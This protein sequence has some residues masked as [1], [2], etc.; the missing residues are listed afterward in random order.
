MRARGLCVGALTL[1][2]HVAAAA[3]P[4]EHGAHAEHPA[5]WSMLAFHALGLTILIGVLVYFA[6][7]PLKN[8]LRDRSDNLRRQLDQAKAAVQR[9]E[10]AN[11]EIAA[12]LARIADENETLVREAADIAELERVRAVERAEA[13]ADR[14]REEAKR[15]ADQEIE[16]ARAALQTEAAKLAVSLAGEMVKANL[17][18]EDDRR[19]LSD[20]VARIGGPS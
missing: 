9:A 1:V 5:D 13:A 6:G 3:E 16:R 14:V 17:T 8:F 12:R 15:A 7:E 11:A 10:A 19:L 20:F 4:A 18:P 2:A